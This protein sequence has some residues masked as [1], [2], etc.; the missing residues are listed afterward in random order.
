MRISA[1]VR[2][3]VRGCAVG[4]DETFRPSAGI[5]CALGSELDSS[6]DVDGLSADTAAGAVCC[7]LT[8]WLIV[9]ARTSFDDAC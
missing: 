8:A 7:R 1:G 3:T 6:D 4:A 9:W 5:D 2:L